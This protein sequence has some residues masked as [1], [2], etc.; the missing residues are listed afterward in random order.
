MGGSNNGG[1]A[2]PVATAQ[3]PVIQQPV[4]SLDPSDFPAL[5]AVLGGGSNSNSNN[6]NQSQQHQIQQVNIQQ[7]NGTSSLVANSSSTS[8]LLNASRSVSNSSAGSLTKAAS[9]SAAIAAAILNGPPGLVEKPSGKGNGFASATDTSS[10]STVKP[11]EN[12][13]NTIPASKEDSKNTEESSE[14]TGSFPA[15]SETDKPTTDMERFGMKGLLNVIRMENNDETAV[16]I[17][18]DLSTLGL[19]SSSLPTANPPSS[20]LVDSSEGVISKANDTSAI[21]S[22]DDSAPS[23]V[24]ANSNA[25][26]SGTTSA[27]GS[28]LPNS[29]P[30]SAGVIGMEGG[31]VS[32]TF[33]LGWHGA[34]DVVTDAAALDFLHHP[35]AVSNANSL[36]PPFTIPRCYKIGSVG[37]QTD[38]LT[39]FTD[40][41][42]FFIFYT[43]PRDTMQELAAQELISR[44]WRY[45]KQLR[46]WLTKDPDGEEPRQQQNSTGEQGTYI[47]FDPYTWEKT[48][49]EYY[50]DYS[51]IA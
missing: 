20:F 27:T 21:T 2:S 12:T 45:H 39:T 17:G 13:G 7:R 16:A 31:Y 41:T 30:G 14:P 23:D 48:K 3:Q 29:A 15:K 10:A 28:R 38:K 6:T 25:V 32:K 47:F 26:A 35:F 44:S 42:L 5:G 33:S 22:R 11:N 43:M 34:G 49:K 19:G 24:G 46:L 1:I 51:M 50:L 36:Q 9:S 40:E 18:S 8:N 4:G 37:V